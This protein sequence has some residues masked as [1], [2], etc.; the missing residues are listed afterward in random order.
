MHFAHL[1]SLANNQLGFF[2]VYDGDFEK[3]TQD[4]AE[5]LG[6]AFDLLFKFTVN[7]PPTPTAKNAAA[8]TRWVEAHDLAP[9]GFYSAYPGLQVQDIR[10]LL[11]T[12]TAVQ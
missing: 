6:P 12:G 1:V 7:P 5:K 10:E 8:F 2:T 11:A 9:L 4:F 3:Y